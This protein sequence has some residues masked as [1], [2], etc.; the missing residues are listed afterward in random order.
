V[1]ENDK[2]QKENYRPI[3][4]LSCVGKVME[5]IV[6]NEL[7]DYCMANNLL[8]WRNSGFKRKDSTINQLIHIVNKIYASLSVG[9]DVLMVFLDVAKAFDKV[10][11][12][13]LIHKL[14]QFGIND[15]LLKWFES[16]LSG[17]YQ[18]VVV[19]GCSS[20]WILVTAGVPQGS[21]LGPL[22]FLIFVN[23]IVDDISCD[24]YLFADDTSLFCPLRSTEDILRINNDLA[25]IATWAAQWRVTFNTAKTVHIVFSKKLNRPGTIPIKFNGIDIKRVHTYCHLGL[26][27][28]VGRPSQ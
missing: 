13:G 1:H 7:Y 20:E 18:R 2:Q 12:R 3:S 6:Y 11:H 5:R 4:L 28:D 24:P 17:R 26:I 16:Y 25:S 27:F 9:D 8:T 22:L 23:D 15:N 10:Y 21:I 14:E 19:N